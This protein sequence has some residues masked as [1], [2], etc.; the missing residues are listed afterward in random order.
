LDN[1]RRLIEVALGHAPPDTMIENCVL[2]DVATR[3]LA[4]ATRQPVLSVW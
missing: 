4:R 3:R 2:V 1:R